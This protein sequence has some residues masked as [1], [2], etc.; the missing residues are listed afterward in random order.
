ML[1]KLVW[2]FSNTFAYNLSASSYMQ[3]VQSVLQNEVDY[4]MAHTGNLWDEYARWV[5]I[6]VSRDQLE[7]ICF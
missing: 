7:N 6:T 1:Y 4:C 2:L 5:I 3:H